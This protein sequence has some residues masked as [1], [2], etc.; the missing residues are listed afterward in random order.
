MHMKCLLN[1]NKYFVEAVH[2]SDLYLTVTPLNKRTDFIP[3]Q[4]HPQTTLP[5]VAR[6][7][8]AA[9]CI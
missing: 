8:P 1:K 6:S 7:C 3:C 4:R 5:Y 2:P 9:A